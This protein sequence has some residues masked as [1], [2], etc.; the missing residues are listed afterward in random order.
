MQI[1][2][3]MESPA[4]GESK[5]ERTACIAVLAGAPGLLLT[6]FAAANSTSLTIRADLVLTVL[7]MLVLVTA[8]FVAR[9]AG[10]TGAISPPIEPVWSTATDWDDLPTLGRR[11]PNC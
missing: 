7:D 5:A 11:F 2:P 6:A 4:K 3:N 1:E 9:R 8:W 10:R